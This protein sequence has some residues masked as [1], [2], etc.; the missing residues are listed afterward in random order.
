MDPSNLP[1]HQHHQC[2]SGLLQYNGQHLPPKLLSKTPRPP[3]VRIAPSGGGLT[4]PPGCRVGSPRN[5]TA[6][7]TRVAGEQQ[8][9]PQADSRQAAAVGELAPSSVTQQVSRHGSCATQRGHCTMPVCAQYSAGGWVCGCLKKR[10]WRKGCLPCSRVGG[11]SCSTATR[12]RGGCWPL[13][14]HWQHNSSRQEALQ[15]VAARLCV[16]VVP[17]RPGVWR[18]QR[19]DGAEVKHSR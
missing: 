10:V 16:G 5:V 12:R 9:T 7:G 14:C 15:Y 3:A 13:Q 4:R 2:M 11:G 19:L 17:T 8:Q 1:C 6:G 18:T